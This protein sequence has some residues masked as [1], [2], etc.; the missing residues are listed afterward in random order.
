MHT[1]EV[2]LFQNGRKTYSEQKTLSSMDLLFHTGKVGREAFLGLI[3]TWNRQG[4]I[5]FANHGQ[6]YLYVAM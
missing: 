4:M 5:G 6:T 2:N 1:Y 3:N